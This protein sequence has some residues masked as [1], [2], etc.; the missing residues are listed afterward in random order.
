MALLIKKLRGSTL[1]ESIVAMVLLMVCLGIATMIYVNVIESGNSRQKFHAYALIH[2]VSVQAKIQKKYIDE[3]REEEG[4][5]MKKTIAKYGGMEKT[6]I[7]KIT[8]TD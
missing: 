7:M 2:Q 1:I 8:A 5:V 4:L 3:E 6:Y